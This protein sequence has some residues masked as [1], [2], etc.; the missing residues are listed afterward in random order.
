VSG[1]SAGA[2]GS[3]GR[4]AERVSRGMSTCIDQRQ[5]V[6]IAEQACQSPCYIACGF[7]GGRQRGFSFMTSLMIVPGSA[8]GARALKTV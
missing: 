5:P 6:V 4:R 2:W 8:P 7:R 1:C 3:S